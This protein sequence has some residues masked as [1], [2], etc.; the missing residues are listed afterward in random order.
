M[1]GAARALAFFVAT[2]AAAAP[3]AGP[4]SPHD[5]RPEG[6]APPPTQQQ[7]SPA[8]PS[9]AQVLSGLHALN[10]AA[11]GAGAQAAELGGSARVRALGDRVR[12]DVLVADR[13]VEGL[14]R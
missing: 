9:T 6:G 8:G 11:A 3:A 14:A 12:R 13:Q 10:R 1:R 7:G 2:L 5:E 4:L